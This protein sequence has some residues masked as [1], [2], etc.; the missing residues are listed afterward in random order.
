MLPEPLLSWIEASRRLNGD[1]SPPAPSDLLRPESPTDSRKALAT[2]V[3]QLSTTNRPVFNMPTMSKAVDRL[4]VFGIGWS[5]IDQYC[6]AKFPAVFFA[7]Y[8]VVAALILLSGCHIGI[9]VGRDVVSEKLPDLVFDED[10]LLTYDARWVVFRKEGVLAKGYLLQYS[11]YLLRY[12]LALQG[13]FLEALVRHGCRTYNQIRVAINLHIVMEQDYWSPIYSRIYIRGPK[14]PSPERLADP[15]FPRVTTGEV[16]E[17]RRVERN[18]VLELML[19]LDATQVMWSRRDGRKTVQIEELVPTDSFRH[20][21]TDYVLNRYL[22]SIWETSSAAFVHTDGAV[23]AYLKEA[24]ELRKNSDLR[25][26]GGKA[27][28]YMKLFRIDGTIQMKEW[29]DLTWKF[30]FGNELVMEYLKSI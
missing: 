27:D 21:Q 25:R 2:L 8:H 12:N 10:G 16:T 28:G 26:Y 29:S 1:A 14:A 11:D 24:Y 23:R 20:S 6:R 9:Y 17:H 4:Q 18:P 3:E 30:F 22:H 13:G 7:R 19:P 15:W 5:E